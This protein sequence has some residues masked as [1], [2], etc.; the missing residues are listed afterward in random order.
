MNLRQLTIW[1]LPFLLQVRNDETTR[2]NLEN[3]WYLHWS[4]VLNGF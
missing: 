1:D 2:M 3:D 4:N